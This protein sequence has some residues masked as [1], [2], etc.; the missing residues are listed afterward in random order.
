MSLKSYIILNGQEIH[1]TKVLY[2]RIFLVI[3]T[4]DSYFILNLV[5]F[6]KNSQN[7]IHD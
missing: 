7:K 1:G 4:F 2:F 3:L 6:F 5:F